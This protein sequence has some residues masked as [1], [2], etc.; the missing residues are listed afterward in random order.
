M[1]ESFFYSS[2]FTEN[3]RDA[4]VC[5][6]NIRWYADCPSKYA[7]SRFQN[8]KPEI[9]ALPDVHA[10]CPEIINANLTF[11]V[12]ISV[13]IFVIRPALITNGYGSKNKVR[14]PT[15]H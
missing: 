12:T 9:A 11:R 2:V 5:V 15:A 1:E 6:L 10:F 13:T 14:A 3:S 8:G 4:R 7:F